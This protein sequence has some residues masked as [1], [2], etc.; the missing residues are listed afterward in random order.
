MR[1]CAL[2]FLAALASA[3]ET[4]I[5]QT[6]TVPDIPAFSLLPAANCG[7]AGDVRRCEVAQPKEWTADERLSMQAAIRR[8]ATDPLVRGL[9]VGAQDN[10]YRGLRRY[11]NDTQ[12]STTGVVPAFNPGFVS[13]SLKVIGITD[14]FFQTE[15]VRD[16]ISDYRFGDL[17]LI[18]ELV[19]AYDN[20]DGSSK[21]EFTAATG[22]VS[23]DDRWLYTNRV[24]Y[25]TYLGVYA[26]T[27]TLYATG[28]Y[29]EARQ[30][31]R[32]FATSMKVPLP[33]I[34]GL[35]SPDETFADILAHLILDSRAATYLEPQVVRWFEANV[36]P[37]L[38]EKAQ[39]F[40][41]NNIALASP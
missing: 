16:P 9:V 15:H 13:Y 28:R 37:A 18:H 36:F 17:V 39:R 32:S 23:K 29:G 12:D 3:T 8:L 22:W 26:D 4:L 21:R 30:R 33:T 34:Q 14:A 1:I 19:H 27:L 38:R 7:E 31:D 40:T 25:S 20:R 5:G 41:G 24:D 10:G 2:A 11:A 6:A 35:A